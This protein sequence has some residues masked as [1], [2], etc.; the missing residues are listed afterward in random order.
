MSHRLKIWLLLLG[1]TSYAAFGMGRLGHNLF[2]QNV[3]EGRKAELENKIAEYEKQLNE[4]KGRS[5]TLANQISQFNAQISLTELKIEQTQDQ[6]DLLSGRIDTLATSVSG[7]KKAFEERVI[8]SYKLARLGS[9]PIFMVG[10]NSDISTT[11]K[12][13]YLKRVQK[14]DNRLLARLVSAQDTYNSQKSEL[15]SLDKV[16]AAQK[17]DLDSKKQSKARL[18]QI[19]KND[20]KMYQDLLA[21]ARSEFDAIQAIISGRGDETEVGRVS[22]G[23]K[24]ATVIG[25]SDWKQGRSSASCNSSAAH[26]HF[27]VSKNNIAENPFNYLSPS[28]SFEN[29]SGPGECS[30]GDP[31]NPTGNWRWPIDEK[32][33]FSQ[34]YG[35]TW[36]VNNTWVGRIYQS[37]NGIDINSQSSPDVKAVKSGTLYRGSFTGSRG[38]RL[39]Y[40]RVRHDEGGLSTLYLHINY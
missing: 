8:A 37:H 32:I 25:W 3:D 1:L 35:R 28:I 15:E 23:S 14:S 33:S 9:N 34:G 29:C 40:V 5:T 30:P 21:A 13:E 20:E 7:L 38:C 2:A 31:F 36:A 27:I 19:T 17:L 24:I 10:V 4:L 18:L 26:L 11:S 16:L 39:R 6:I 22:E 12:F